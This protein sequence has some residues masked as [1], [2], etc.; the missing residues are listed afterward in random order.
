MTDGR[1][2]VSGSAAEAAS[3][4][5]T[6]STG[7]A[8]ARYKS[9]GRLDTTFG[10]D[11]S[12]RDAFSGT[13]CVANG[14]AIQGDGKI[15]LAGSVAADGGSGA[16]VGLVR[17][18]SDAGPALPG[19]RD[20]SFGLLGN[21]TVFSNLGLSTVGP[22]ED[23]VVAA[24]G[25]ILVAGHVSVAGQSQFFLAH[26]TGDGRLVGGPA[27]TKFSD[28]SDV[29]TSMLMQSNGEIVVVG[30][31]GQLGSNA[32]WAVVRYAVG[33]FG[34]DAMF[35]T[36]GKLTIDFAGGFDRADA[37]VQQPDAKLI[38]GGLANIGGRTLF[39]LARLVP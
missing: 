5:T 39:A 27:L 2:V 16:N 25:T 10:L 20:E 6:G 14:L 1:I 26:F 17:Y 30:Q 3:S 38:I 36:G 34:E 23:L 29:A 13:F 12:V 35:G 24:D 37:V 21:G 28:Q 9:D 19:E 18:T 8:V 11:G 7:F 22:A 33:G 31:A 32:D 15:V 4:G